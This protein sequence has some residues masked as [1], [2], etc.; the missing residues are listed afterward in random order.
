MSY[1]S[2][3]PE[4]TTWAQRHCLMLFTSFAER[5][6]RFAY[7]SS[8]MG[9]CFQIWIDLPADGQ[10]CVHAAGVDGR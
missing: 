1:A 4:I 7:T 9:D 10:V 2:V 8:K 5:E 3:D 6:S